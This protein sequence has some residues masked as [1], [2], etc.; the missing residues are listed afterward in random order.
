MFNDD[1]SVCSVVQVLERK[2]ILPLCTRII[3]SCFFQS[4]FYRW[5]FMS[6][7]RKSR[8]SVLLCRCSCLIRW[9]SDLFRHKATE[10]HSFTVIRSDKIFLGDHQLP[11][12]TEVHCFVELLCMW[13]VTVKTAV[14]KYLC[15]V[16]TYIYAAL[17]GQFQ[18]QSCVCNGW[19][20]VTVHTHLRSINIVF[21]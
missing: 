11:C 4:K 7:L 12:R 9:I 19:Y 1:S 8:S 6:S 21:V 13:V 17:Q 14:C 20:A 18:E 2:L 3:W 16:Y 5:A 10:T 15:C